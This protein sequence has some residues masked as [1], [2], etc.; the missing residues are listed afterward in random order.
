[1]IYSCLTYMMIYSCV[2][3]VFASLSPSPSRAVSAY[4]FIALGLLLVSRLMSQHVRQISVENSSEK[5]RVPIVKN[6]LN[7]LISTST[8]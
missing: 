8:L 2:Q 1:M 3:L 4:V 5:E 6:K 7:Y